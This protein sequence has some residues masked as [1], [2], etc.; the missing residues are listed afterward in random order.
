MRLWRQPEGLRFSVSASTP[1]S[2]P[3][4]TGERRPLPAPLC[5]QCLV[6]PLGRLDSWWC[7]PSHQPFQPI[8][9]Y[10]QHSITCMGRLHFRVWPLLKMQPFPAG[11]P[12]KGW[13]IPSVPLV[14]VVS[15][16]CQR[17]GS[18]TMTCPGTSPAPIPPLLMD[19]SSAGDCVK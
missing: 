4:Q 19:H 7:L 13:A 9:M 14:P 3:Q 1:G 16:G 15:G 10:M 11:E 17:C 2:L 5:G 6:G 18:A 8:S 12:G